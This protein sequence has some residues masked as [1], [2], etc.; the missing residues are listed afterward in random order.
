MAIARSAAYLV[1]R[2]PDAWHRAEVFDPERLRARPLPYTFLPFGGGSHTC[3]GMAFALQQMKA[4]LIEI[5]CRVRL[6][7]RPGYRPRTQ[8][9]GITVVLSGGLPLQCTGKAAYVRVSETRR[10]ARSRRDR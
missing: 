1:Q 4:P 5:V 3:L 9:R 6:R 2:H 10:C 7:V 8:R